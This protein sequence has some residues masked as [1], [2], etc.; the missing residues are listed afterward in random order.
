[1]DMKLE[2]VVIPV[3]D[4]DRAKAFYERMGFA[5]DVDHAA[6]D[7]FR[8]VQVTPPGSAASVC[9]GIGVNPPDSPVKGLHLVVTDIAAAVAE[10]RDRG[11]EVSDPFHV[12]PG[13]KADG[14]HADHEDYATFAEIADP[15]G[16][17]WLLQEVASRG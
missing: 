3:T 5:T 11:V 7:D 1:M 2:L 14:A 6:G 4:V 9:F 13:G 15:D 10:L 8:V 17:L 12:G 16:N